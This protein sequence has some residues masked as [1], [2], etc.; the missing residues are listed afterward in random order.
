MKDRMHNVGRL[1]KLPLKSIQKL[2]LVQN[3]VVLA[4]VCAPQSVH[5]A[6][7]LHELH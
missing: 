4:I 5:I 7:L 6:S 3:A 1:G 2:Q